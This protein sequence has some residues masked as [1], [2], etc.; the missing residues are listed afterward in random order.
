M[1]ILEDHGEIYD[2]DYKLTSNW[3]GALPVL[4]ATN[5][6]ELIGFPTSTINQYDKSP[7]KEAWGAA[8]NHGLY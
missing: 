1:F 3:E 8:L 5:R 6:G 4:A 2:L 7:R